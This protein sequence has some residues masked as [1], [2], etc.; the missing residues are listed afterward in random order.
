MHARRRA[1][2]AA[3]SRGAVDRRRR[4][5]RLVHARATARSSRTGSRTAIGRAR[6]RVRIASPVITAGPVLGTLAEVAA[7]GR[8]DLAGVVDRRR[9]SRSSSQWREQRPLGLEDPARSRRVLEH[10][11]F[12]GK[13]STPWAPDT[14]HDFMHAKVTVADDMVFVGSFNL[15][16]SGEQNAENVLEIH[17]AGAG[18]AAWPRSSTRSAARYPDADVRAWRCAAD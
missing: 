14:P 10:A 3:T 16:R 9:P 13:P 12:R 6:A 17:D 1:A 11:D 8:V 7:E 15:S 4:G 18:R 5:A 2:R